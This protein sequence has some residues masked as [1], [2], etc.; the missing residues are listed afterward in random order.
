M[1]RKALPRMG[2]RGALIVLACA[3]A[4]AGCR[5]GPTALP[6]GTTAPVNTPTR[7]AERPGS[8]ATAL[9]YQDPDLAAGRAGR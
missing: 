3:V 6:A 4:L 2:C 8:A 5:P 1:A 7:S 9:P